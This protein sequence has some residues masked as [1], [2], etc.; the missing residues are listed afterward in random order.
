MWA[1]LTINRP[2]GAAQASTGMQHWVNGQRMFFDSAD[3]CGK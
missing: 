3:K 2:G 1:A